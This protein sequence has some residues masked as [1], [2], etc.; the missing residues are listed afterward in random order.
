MKGSAGRRARHIVS[1]RRSHDDVVIVQ[2]GRGRE[3]SVC[4][5]HFRLLVEVWIRFGTRLVDGVLV[6]VG[7]RVNSRVVA[8]VYRFGLRCRVGHGPPVSA[9][10]S[11]THSLGCWMIIGLDGPAVVISARTSAW[12]EI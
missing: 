10:L 8:G 9:I 11:R 2:L 1:V 5:V 6:I 7:W 4:G 12:L 3:A